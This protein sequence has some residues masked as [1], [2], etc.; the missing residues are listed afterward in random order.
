MIDKESKVYIAGHRGMV[1]RAIWNRLEESG[2]GN[3]S[4]TSSTELDLKNQ[5]LVNDFMATTRPDIVVLAAKKVEGILDNE[6]H[7][8]SVLYENLTMQSNLIEASRMN[9][10]RQLIFIANPSIYP[11]RCPLPM[12]EECLTDGALDT[13]HQWYGQAKLAGLKLCEAI[14][15]QYRYNY[16]TLIPCNLYGPY[17]RFEHAFRIVPAMMR[18]FHQA[19]EQGGNVTIWGSGRSRREFLYVGDLADAVKFLIENKTRC[20]AYNVGTGRDVLISELAATMQEVVGHTGEV[21]WE[22]VKPDQER[23]KWMDVSRLKSEG[24]EARTELREGLEK[25]YE[26]FLQLP[27]ELQAG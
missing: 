27:Q 13:T 23:R 6:Q 16:T 10:V 20:S 4:G 21:H 17:D 5:E 3:L 11:A 9:K 22:M 2:Y 18:R 1:G 8:Y 26:W 7:P 19:A 14:R 15:R 12:R 25:T 24:W